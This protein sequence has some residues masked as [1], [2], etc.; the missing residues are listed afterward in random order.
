[1]HK[2]PQEVRERTEV[3]EDFGLKKLLGR[4]ERVTI[5]VTA[6]EYNELVSL[7]GVTQVRGLLESFVA[8]VTGSGRHIWPQC[9]LEALSWFEA[10]CHGQQVIETLQKENAER[11]AE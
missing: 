9:R 6:E 10:H 4:T 8:D 2:I 7:V 1:M 5:D 11:K 3:D